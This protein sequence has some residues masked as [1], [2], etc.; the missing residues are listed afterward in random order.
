ME[1][2]I[3]H[4][5]KRKFSVAGTPQ[6]NGVVERKNKTVQEMAKT[7]LMDSKLIDI[8]RVQGVHTTIHIHNIE[9]LI[10]N[11]EMVEIE[12]MEKNLHQ[13]TSRNSTPSMG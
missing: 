3:E 7:M 5:I 13:R 6:E 12:T 8:F 4:G 10:N 1:F 11:K 2:Y 9:M